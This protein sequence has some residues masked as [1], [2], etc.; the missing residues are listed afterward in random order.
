MKFPLL[1]R[2]V[3]FNCKIEITPKINMNTSLNVFVASVVLPGTIII[4]ECRK[5]ESTNE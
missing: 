5:N 3:Y 1:G 2:H 4:K